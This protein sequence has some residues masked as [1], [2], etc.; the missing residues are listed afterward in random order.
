MAPLPHITV[1]MGTRNDAAYL[2]QQLASLKAQDHP[3]WSLWISDDGS[4]D[5]PRDVFCAPVRSG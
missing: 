5:D 2:R 3:H 1:L 4:T